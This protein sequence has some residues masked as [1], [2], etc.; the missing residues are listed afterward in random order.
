MTLRWLRDYDGEMILQYRNHKGVWVA[1]PTVDY[2]D[3]RRE[4]TK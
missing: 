3:V 2:L 4:L 1:V